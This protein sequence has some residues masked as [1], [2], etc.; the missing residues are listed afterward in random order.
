MAQLGFVQGCFALT[1]LLRFPRRNRQ[2]VPFGAGALALLTGFCAQAQTVSAP[3]L[4]LKP[5]SLLQETITQ[6]VRKQLPTFVQ[7]DAISGQTDVKTTL[8]GHVVIR[9]GDM[10]IKADHVD[11]DH[12]SDLAKAV[13]NVYI[14]RAGNVYQGPEL[15]LYLD[16]FEG[17]FTQPT[18]DYP[19]YGGHGKAD[20]IDFVDSANTQLFK[21][22]YTTCQRRPGPSWLPDWLIRADKISLDSDRNVGVAENA[23]LEF[24]DVTLLS[25]SSI[26][27]PLGDT[28]KSGLL[29]PAIGAD[30]IGGLQYS[31]PYYI[32]LAP[33]RDATITP[34]YWSR[35]G[36]Q[37]EAEF[38]Y[39]ESSNNPLIP[40]QGLARLDYMANDSMRNRDRWGVQFMQTGL[41]NTSFAGGN[42]GLGLNINRVSD[43]NYWKDFALAN[44][45]GVQRLLS[46]NASLTWSNGTWTTGLTVQRWQTLQDLA[47]INN[48]ITPPFDRV[49][50]ASALYTRSNVSGF[51][52]S[53]S[54]Q[55]TRFESTRAYECSQ[56][57]ATNQANCAPNG[58]REVVNLQLSRP[59]LVPAGYLTPK[60]QLHSA[61]YQFDTALSNGQTSAS[62]VVPTYSVDSGVVFE[63]SSRI[64]DRGWTQTL[65]P[66]ALY[67]QTPFVAQ[68]YLPNYDTGLN[69]FNFSSIFSENVFSGQDRVA[70]ARQMT[71]GATSR[72]IDPNTGAEG[73]RFALAQRLRLQDQQIYL[74]GGSV[75][76]DRFSDILMGA[77]FN[78]TRSWSAETVVQYNPK[79]GNSTQGMVGARYTPG[80]YR[81]LTAAYRTQDDPTTNAAITRQVDMGW[82]WPLS[83]LWG[84]PDEA[85]GTGR[86]L[87]E[88]RWYGVGRVSYST[89]DH[90]PIESIVGFEYDAGCWLGR[91]VNEQLQIADGVSRQRILF[92]LE[93]VGFS[94]VGTGALSSFKNNVPRYEPLRQPAVTPSRFGDYE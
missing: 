88:G 50:Q 68:N 45:A 16:A 42:L 52:Y 31:Q 66:R 48:R 18:F 76:Q 81:T 60:V 37:G 36:L 20:R 9:R 19:K 25:S 7:S 94:R 59:F 54:T 14:N 24:K 10:L 91:I 11:Y 5:S 23:K 15:N 61:N 89:L 2:L 28:R 22:S 53:V 93:F 33:N 75:Q 40:V 72:L 44:G 71:L 83:D 34:T 17:F 92:Q 80:S 43:D 4:V 21:A 29:P 32:N 49:P 56:T 87:G 6:D 3:A 70:D 26:E 46:N 78:L 84:R 86:G 30:N 77:S 82:Q 55:V 85:L 39:L 47:D 79:L 65:E 38:R 35:R 67:V 73:A 69:S 12:A 27:F 63:R 64:F 58:N 51:D 90:K 13:G 57:D 1:F 74:P 62:V 8:D 41:P